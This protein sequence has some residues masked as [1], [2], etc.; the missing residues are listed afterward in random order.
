MAFLLLLGWLMG[1]VLWR[2]EL[3]G[4]RTTPDGSAR[5]EKF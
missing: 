3:G 4:R 2:F 1:D 5:A